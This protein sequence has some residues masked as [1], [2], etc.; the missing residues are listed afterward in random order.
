MTYK[1]GSKSRMTEKYGNIPRTAAPRMRNTMRRILKNLTLSQQPLMQT[2]NRHLHP[3]LRLR[4][5]LIRQRQETS[6]GHIQNRP[7]MKG[8]RR[9]LPYPHHVPLRRRLY[10]DHR[11]LVTN[12]RGRQGPVCWRGSSVR[13]DHHIFPQRAGM[14]TRS[15]WQFGR[16]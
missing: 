8:L 9:H 13:Q 7:H 4:S 3:L 12:L 15:T 16:R 2:R 14:K 5:H 1:M 11:L 10:R 6:Q